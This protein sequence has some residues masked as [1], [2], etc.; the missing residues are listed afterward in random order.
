MGD[1]TERS[2]N[3]GRIGRILEHLLAYT[4]LQHAWQTA[5]ELSA[6]EIIFRIC[7]CVY[8]QIRAV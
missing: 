3:V 4:V 5:F 6:L 1:A 7:F 2:G 8:K